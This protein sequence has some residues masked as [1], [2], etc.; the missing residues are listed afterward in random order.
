MHSILLAYLEYEDL[1][2]RNLLQKTYSITFDTFINHVLNLDALN[3]TS[4]VIAAMTVTNVNV[5]ADVAAMLMQSCYATTKVTLAAHACA[6]L[7]TLLSPTSS[8]L[9]LL[10]DFVPL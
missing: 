8:F 4:D 7:P 9:L 10:L 1:I 2:L 5:D 6:L 3:G